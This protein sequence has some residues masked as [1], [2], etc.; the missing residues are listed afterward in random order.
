MN[1]K[2]ARIPIK[3]GQRWRNFV[4]QYGVPYVVS[5]RWLRF[6]K[7]SGGHFSEGGYIPTEGEKSGSDLIIAFN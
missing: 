1:K 4:G 5:N 2:V 6:P 7:K 3:A